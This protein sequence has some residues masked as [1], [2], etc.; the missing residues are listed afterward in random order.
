MSTL[1]AGVHVDAPGSAVTATLGTTI[2]ALDAGTYSYK[3]SYVTNFGE[4]LPSAKSDDII[5][6]AAGSV[7]LSAIPTAT[8]V[9][10]RKIYRTAADGATWLLLATLSNTSATTY[11][12]VIA[13]D[14]LGA[15]PP[16]QSSADST[17]LIDGAVVF[18]GF[19]GAS[20]ALNITAA[21]GGG[22][23]NATPLTKSNNLV[24]VVATIADSV[25]LPALSALMVGVEICVKNSAANSMNVFPASGQ[26][27]NALAANTA[28]AVA[29]GAVA[30]FVAAS[31]TNWQQL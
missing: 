26:T 16:T 31:T 22:Q 3:V 9:I 12:D 19:R 10:A 20:L 24:S 25:A 17:Q 5:V 8:H 1:L 30:R 13:D 2:G 4:T 14:A 27:I 29:G 21:A 23:A 7:L 11:L 28:V 15:A 18:N 6:S